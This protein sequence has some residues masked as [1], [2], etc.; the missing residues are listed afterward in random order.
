MFSFVPNLL[1]YLA[2]YIPTFKVFRIWRC[3]QFMLVCFRFFRMFVWLGPI[4]FVRVS[5]PSSSIPSKSTHRSIYQKLNIP[6]NLQTSKKFPPRYVLTFLDK[7]VRSCVSQGHCLW[8]STVKRLR[9]RT[10]FNHSRALKVGCL[11]VCV[12]R[13]DR[14]RS[15][16]LVKKRQSTYSSK[17]E[18]SVK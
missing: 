3:W 17:N 16:L 8:F 12:S 11:A 13:V 14:Y 6:P 7:I 5:S 2:S 15:R 1:S 4:L 9:W 18:C 10:K